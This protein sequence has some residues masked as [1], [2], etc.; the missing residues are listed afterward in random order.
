M[1]P[2]PTNRADEDDRAHNFDPEIELKLNGV[3][4]KSVSRMINSLVRGRK[5][6]EYIR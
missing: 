2:V 3:I 1:S 6:A 5:K 4:G